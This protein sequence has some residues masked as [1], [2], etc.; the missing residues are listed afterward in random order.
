VAHCNNFML[1]SI[2]QAVRQLLIHMDAKA[3][4][5]LIEDLKQFIAITVGQSEARLR[6]ELAN[7]E[8]LAQL[9]TRLTER[10]DDGFA[11]AG[12]GVVAT[13]EDLDK[14]DR[15]VTRLEQRAV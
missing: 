13:Q 14:L 12:Q 11:G 8:D 1:G 6:E 15:R 3:L 4:E 10:M 5:H 9:E 2:T 7:K